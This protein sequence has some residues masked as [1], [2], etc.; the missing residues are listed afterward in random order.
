MYVIDLITGLLIGVPSNF[1]FYLDIPAKVCFPLTAAILKIIYKAG[2]ILRE[3]N[4][5]WAPYIILI[6][7]GRVYHYAPFLVQ[8]PCYVPLRGDISHLF[9]TFYFSMLMNVM[10]LLYINI[11][12]NL[13][14][15]KYIHIYL[16]ILYRYKNIRIYLSARK[17]RFSILNAYQPSPHIATHILISTRVVVF[18]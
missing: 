1:W 5:Y 17:I 12:K 7:I 8:H 2:A 16:Y 13:Q 10:F 18:A 9:V 11:R 6:Q 4:P 14:E 15:A 3:F